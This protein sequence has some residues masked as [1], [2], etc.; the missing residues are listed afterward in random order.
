MAIKFSEKA[1]ANLSQNTD[2]HLLTKIR[3]T[4]SWLILLSISIMLCAVLF[5]GI[6]GRITES[7][8]VPGITLLSDGVVPI[9]APNNGT[10]KYLN[11]EA[12]SKLQIGQVV[13][14]IYNPEII[15][16]IKNAQEEYRALAKEIVVLKE[17]HAKLIEYRLAQEKIKSEALSRLDKETLLSRER[18]KELL[19]SYKDL[20]AK[21]VV[22]KLEYYRTLDE[23]VQT[24]HSHSSLIMQNIDSQSTM[25]NLIWEG[26]EKLIEL[27]QKLE[28]KERAN[29]IAE[30]IFNEAFWVTAAS[31][32]K[33]IEVFKE[34]GDFVTTGDRIALVASDISGGIYLVAFVPIEDG[35]RIKNGMRA[36]FSPS[37]FPSAKHGF[38]KAVVRDVS[39]VPLNYEAVV[40]ELVN[41]SL[42]R[43][44]A[45][46]DVVTRVELELIPDDDSSSGFAWT[47]KNSK[48]EE[49]KNGV[50]G[51]IIIDVE[52]RSPIS[53]IIPALKE[54]F[55][56]KKSQEEK[57]DA[58]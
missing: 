20:L 56:S 12:G 13:G 27:T 45:G 21:G 23:A 34:H 49:L 22:S 9:V 5:W 32:G 2:L 7:I 57:A 38:V 58:L 41:E 18:V 36:F 10:L 24:E 44:F 1:L 47:G 25:Q 42:A 48:N 39:E 14:Q 55:T 31:T 53:Y 37:G 52:Y 16:R 43:K 30:Y 19:T 54:L 11:I 4:Y 33:V 3:F 46:K 28:E 51:D 26:E 35:K 17:G 15:S 8:K 29:N 40:A 50:Y 6:F